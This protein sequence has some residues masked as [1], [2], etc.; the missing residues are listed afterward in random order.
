MLPSSSL[1]SEVALTSKIG[2]SIETSAARIFAIAPGPP[3]S[4]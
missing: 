1:R 4:Q 2:M 3:Y